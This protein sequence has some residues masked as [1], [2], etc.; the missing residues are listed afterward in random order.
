MRFHAEGTAELH[1]RR[2]WRFLRGVLHGVP[3]PALLWRHG[4]DRS[5]LSGQQ[6]SQFSQQA[7][8]G[9]WLREK[10]IDPRLCGKEA[11]LVRTS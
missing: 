4:A 11:V 10:H 9:M 2:A 7:L 1:P 5:P 6:A 8:V 3:S